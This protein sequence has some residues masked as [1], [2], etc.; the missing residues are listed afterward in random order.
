MIARLLRGLWLVALAVAAGAAWFAVHRF[1]P[2]VGPWVAG[3]AALMVVG[4]LHPAASAGRVIPAQQVDQ[5]RPGLDHRERVG[6]LDT[7][8]GRPGVG[9]FRVGAHARVAVVIV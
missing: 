8:V 4:A 3:F 2:V 7:G 5:R 6:V 9:G 1:G